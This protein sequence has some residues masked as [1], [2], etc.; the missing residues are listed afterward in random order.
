MKRIFTTLITL[1]IFCLLCASAPAAD[2]DGVLAGLQTYRETLNTFTAH[3]VQKK[4]LAL[5]SGDVTSTGTFAYKK[6]GIM[7]WRYD[8]PEDTIMGIKP[9]LITFYFP[10]LKKAKRIHLSQ[11]VD[12]PQWMSLGMGPISDIGGLKE[13]SR[14]AV[15]EANGAT[16]ITIAP[17][18]SKETI[19]EIV[20]TLRKD[21]TPLGVRI[22]EKSGDFTL[23][24]FSEQRVNPPVDDTL[25]DVKIPAGVAVEDI[26]K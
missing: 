24:T 8:P 4:H 6:P 26:G 9:G 19:K 2:V 25:F 12:I 3:F 17:K 7:V 10:S 16:V 18:D 13:S 21:Y 5:L 14:V 1:T 22:T 20:I 23:L 15:S 11:G